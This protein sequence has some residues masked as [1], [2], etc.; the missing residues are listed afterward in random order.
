MGLW[1]FIVEK[2]L[3]MSQ[4]ATDE[5]A[6]T[7]RQRSDL[8]VAFARTLFV[9]G[10]STD[11]TL[12][13]VHRLAQLFGLRAKLV[14]RWGE[15]HLQTEHDD[16]KLISESPANPTGVDMNRVVSTMRAIEDLAAGRLAPG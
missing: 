9:N 4:L 15:L 8:V 2:D 1:I 11:Q 14:L 5:L 6:M 16:A 13:A 7:L 10:Q 3:G 12:S